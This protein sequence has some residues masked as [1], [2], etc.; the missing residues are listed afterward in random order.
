MEFLADESIKRLLIQKDPALKHLFDAV[1]IESFAHLRKSAFAHITDALLEQLYKKHEIEAWRDWIYG[2]LGTDFGPVDLWRFLLRH[3]DVRASELTLM[4]EICKNTLN[5]GGFTFAQLTDLRIN[6]LIGVPGIKH[7]TINK[8]RLYTLSNLDILA[9]DLHYGMKRLYGM[10]YISNSEYYRIAL[11]WTPHRSIVSWY[12]WA[13][14]N[15]WNRY[16]N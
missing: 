12:M 2:N 1:H 4:S 8:M 5:L 11:R 10:D 9:T 7:W 13:Y 6:S 15:S 3:Q 14:Q 16:N